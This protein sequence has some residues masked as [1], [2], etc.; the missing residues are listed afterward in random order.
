MGPLASLRRQG[1]DRVRQRRSAAERPPTPYFV[2]L[3]WESLL[4]GNIVSGARQATSQQP[5]HLPGKLCHRSRTLRFHPLWAH[6]HRRDRNRVAPRSWGC[7]GLGSTPPAWSGKWL[8]VWRSAV[9][10]QLRDPVW[11]SLSFFLRRRK[12]RLPRPVRRRHGRLQGGPVGKPRPACSLR[13]GSPSTGP[14]GNLAR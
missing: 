1:G 6:R 7:P 2:G 14:R 5:P 12:S 4:T 8:L 3:S 9:L 10:P 13:A 11:K